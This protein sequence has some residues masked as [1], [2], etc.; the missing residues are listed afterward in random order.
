MSAEEAREC[1]PDLMARVGRHD[2]RLIVEEDRQPVA[3]V[4]SAEDYAVMRR[5][6]AQRKADFAII[7]QM[8]A[9]FAGVPDEELEREVEKAVA[10][11]R[12]EI[13]AWAAKDRA[14]FAGPMVERGSLSTV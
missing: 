9:A 13:R 10:E 4:V 12:A 14:G 5:I 11:A 3:A 8:Q 1:W 7:E 6:E 2:V